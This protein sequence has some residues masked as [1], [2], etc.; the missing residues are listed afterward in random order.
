VRVSNTFEIKPYYAKVLARRANW[1]ASAAALVE[2][3]ALTGESWVGT[4]LCSERIVDLSF[5][6]GR[7]HGGLLAFW[8]YRPTMLFG[9][10][11]G[12]EKCSKQPLRLDRELLADNP[13]DRTGVVPA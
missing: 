8:F 12:S 7:R 2:F 9:Q 5:D 11:R 13:A 1:I 6:Y 3:D 4:E 10:M